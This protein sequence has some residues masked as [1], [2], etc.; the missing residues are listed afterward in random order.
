MIEKRIEDF[1]KAP[2]FAVVGASTDREKYGNK[3]LRCYQQNGREVVPINP[4]GGLIEGL[5]AKIALA[6]LD[7]PKSH[8]LSVITPPPISLKV[9]E[10]AAGLGIRRIWLQ[11]GAESQAVLDRA[12]ELGIE[13]IAGGPCLLVVLGFR[14]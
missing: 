12:A 2:R 14:A 1:L 11:P 7:D 3:I 8:A 13:L 9:V 4:R 10:E 5:E 6:E